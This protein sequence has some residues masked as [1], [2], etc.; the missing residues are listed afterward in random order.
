MFFTEYKVLIGDTE[1]LAF[2]EKA[3][4]TPLDKVC[5]IDTNFKN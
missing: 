5:K 4:Y 2:F 3:F 1:K